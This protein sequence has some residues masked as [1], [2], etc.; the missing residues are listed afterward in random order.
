MISSFEAV[1]SIF[2]EKV[3]ESFDLKGSSQF[4]NNFYRFP[5]SIRKS[6]RSRICFIS[7]FAFE[8]ILS[9]LRARKLVTAT[10]IL[11][12]LFSSTRYTIFSRINFK[13]KSFLFIL[14][15]CFVLM[16]CATKITTL[17]LSF[18]VGHLAKYL[19]LLSFEN[20]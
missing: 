12:K 11:K 1:C 19:Y 4:I 7:L 5:F 6:E 10:K 18:T 13:Q 17:N 8:F 9:R 15:R 20:I 16:P 3:H 2:K 14:I